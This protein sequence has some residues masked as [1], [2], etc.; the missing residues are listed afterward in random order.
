MELFS[1]P[2]KWFT[3]YIVRGIQQGFRIGFQGS[4]DQLRSCRRNM[5][6]SREHPDVVEAYI[7]NEVKAARLERVG[8][9]DKA[10]K[11]GVHCS[12]FGVIPKK[13]GPNRW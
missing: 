12:P 1:H 13:G 9:R 5:V 10:D 11:G 2:D 3:D 7:A 4:R 8:S 6:S